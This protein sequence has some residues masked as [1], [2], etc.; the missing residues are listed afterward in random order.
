MPDYTHGE[1]IFH[2]VSHIA[3]GVVGLAALISCVVVAALHGN[4]WG[5]V[6]GAVFGA[7]MILLYTTS[8]IYH[9]L[10]PGCTAKRVF[11]VLD[12]C[13]IFLLI[14]GT[15]TPLTLVSIRGESAWLGWTVFGAIWGLAV[16]GISL[17]AVDL[18]SYRVF[19]MVCFLCMGWCIVLTWNVTARAVS[20]DGMLLMLLGGVFYTIGAVLYAIGSK[21]RYFH[22]VFHVFVV[23]GSIMHALCIVLFVM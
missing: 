1:E 15:Y 9:A 14:A 3:G 16:L 5:I 6:S 22:S 23:A 18:K 20:S 21:R 17:N 7:T 8:S 11:Q 12:H 10:R 2:T 4:V 19:S 13:T